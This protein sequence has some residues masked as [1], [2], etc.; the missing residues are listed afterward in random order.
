MELSEEERE[1]LVADNLPIP[2]HLPL[3]MVEEQ[4]LKR[5]RRKIK[6]KVGGRGEEKGRVGFGVETKGVMALRGGKGW[7]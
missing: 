7:D 1:T 5:V 3:T 2:H 6:N 4:N